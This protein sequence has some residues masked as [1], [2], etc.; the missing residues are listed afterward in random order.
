MQK[1][2]T[3]LWFDTQA[4]QA[5]HF[6]V[7]LF[8]D[9]AVNRVSYY[10]ASAANGP[11]QKPVGSV[12]T[13]D[14]TLAGQYYTALNGGPQFPFTEAISLLIT[15]DT[16]D[17]IDHYWNGLLADGGQESQCGWLKDKYGLS[18]QIVPAILGDLM[19]DADPAKVERVS[20]VVMRSVKLNIAELQMAYDGTSD[21]A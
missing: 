4:E 2:V 15:C 20:A 14:F 21:P 18:W 13:V 10:P 6:Y 17:E 19:S 7:A 5:A 9:S 1:I 12:L 8:P 3:N 16:Q 11:A